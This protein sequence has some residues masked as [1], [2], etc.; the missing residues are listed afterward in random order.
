QQA[1]LISMKDSELA[2][3][4]E[5]L[6]STSDTVAE[7]PQAATAAES[8]GL[9]WVWIGLG[10]LLVAAVAWLLL[11]RAPKASPRPRFDTAVPVVPPAQARDAGEPADAVAH[12]AVLPEAP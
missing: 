10:L 9:P 3:V 8:G 2:A 7:A 5:R 11:R 12:S 1:Q 4:Q 6:A